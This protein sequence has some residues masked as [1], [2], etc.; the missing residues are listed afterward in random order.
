MRVH[1]IAT[2]GALMHNLAIALQKAGHQVTGSDD[3]IYEPAR[4]RLALA[5]L[6]PAA[7]GWHESRITIDI[8]LVILGMHAR[9]DNPELLRAQA[10]GLKIV[11]YPEF[12]RQHSQAKTRVAIAGSHGKT[13][14]TAMLMHIL[15]QNN[16]DFDYAVGASVAGFETM[17][18]LSDAPIMVIE[19]DEYLSSPIDN[20]SKFLH[21]APHIAVLTGIAHDHFN[22][23]PTLSGYVRAFRDFA[24]TMSAGG[25]FFYYKNSAYLDE[26]LPALP[27]FIQAKAYDTAAHEIRENRS[28]LR[29]DFIKNT[30]N[31]LIPL[32][33]FGAHNLQ[34]LQAAIMVCQQ[35]GLS[36]AQIYPTLSSFT[37]AA[38][39][40]QIQQQSKDLIVFND[41]GHAP[42]KVAATVEAVRAQYPDY[43]LIA[44]L[45][46]HTFSSLNADFLPNY[47][48]ALAAADVAIAY[49]SPHTLAQKRLPN[50]EAA[51]L[52]GYFERADLQVCQTGE[53]VKNIIKN[54]ILPNIPTI[55]LLMSSGQWGGVEMRF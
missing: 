39:R 14:T 32:S 7:E 28:F 25:H 55:V 36:D 29:P 51:Q 16:I 52:C 38:R 31:S 18:R 21:Y 15:K 34:N 35:L 33:I 1:L 19:A 2:G 54:A 30:Q 40:L 48:Q 27:A 46:L 9:A 24:A 53:A 44:A 47:R 43:Q 17:V 37:G 5:G 50:L 3:E 4:G 42:S 8:Q 45:E 13:T 10:L 23:F 22:V 6:L 26:I 49:F 20:R 12:L 41:F 11:S